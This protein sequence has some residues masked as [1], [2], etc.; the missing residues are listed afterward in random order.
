[1]VAVRWT[2]R[3]GTTKRCVVVRVTKTPT[4]TGIICKADGEPR[5][6][7]VCL[8]RPGQAVPEVGQRGT[9]TF[10]RGGQTGGYWKFDPDPQ[11]TKEH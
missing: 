6:G 5:V 10:T 3:Y 9:L 1:M 7:Y 4:C 2:W 8:F 11:P